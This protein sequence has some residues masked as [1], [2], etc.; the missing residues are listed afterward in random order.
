MTSPP[1]CDF[2]AIAR[3]D[4]D[5][6]VVCEGEHWVAFFPLEPATAGHTLVIPREHV[7]DL[8]QASTDTGRELIEAVIRVGR[9]IKIAVEPD[10]M[11]MITSRG[12]GC[13]ANGCAP[14]SAR[15]AALV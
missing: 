3:G 6:E 12:G 15:R 11:N 13:R 10:G 8:W 2:C 1:D 4:S 14:T 7:K 9:A 5:A